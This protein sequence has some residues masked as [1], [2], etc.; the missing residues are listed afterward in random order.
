VG[1]EGEGVAFQMIPTCID[2]YRTTGIPVRVR[3]KEFHRGGG[4]KKGKSPHCYILR[5]QDQDHSERML[6]GTVLTYKG[7]MHWGSRS[8]G[9]SVKG[10]LFDTCK[11]EKKRNTTTKEFDGRG[12][13]ISVT[14]SGS[15]FH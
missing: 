14:S 11:G 10:T 2:A 15:P 12:R 7:S 4:E 1:W 13:G 6:T 5:G 8:E 9:F 3:R